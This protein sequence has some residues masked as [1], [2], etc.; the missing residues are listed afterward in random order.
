[1]LA[2]IR[3]G[4]CLTSCPTYVLSMHESEGPR[5]RVGMARALAEGHLQV[6][7]DLV[8]HELNCLVC[9]ACSAVC[10]AGVHM[11]PLQVRLRSAIEPDMRRPWRERLLRGLV[12]GWLFMD[13]ARFRLVARLLWVY[14]RSGARWLARRLGLLRVLGLGSSEQLLP[15]VPTR[16][17]V[18]SDDVYPASPG[19]GREVAFF[20]GCVMSTALA[21]IDRATIRVVQRAGHTVRNPRGQGCC[22]ALHA[23]SGD[24]R[25]ALELAR[26]NIAVFEATDGPIVVNSAGCGA[27]LKDYA[28]HFREDSGWAQRAQSFSARV[29][30]LSEVLAPE[31]LPMRKPIAARV[32]YQD[33]CHLLHAQRISRQ[34]RDLLRRITGLELTEIAE[35]G[36]CCGSAGVYNLTNPVQSRQLQQR[37][38]DNAL[39]ADPHIIVTAN[40]GCLLQ[41]RAGLSER[42]SRVNVVH[43]AEL[44]DTATAPPSDASSPA[45]PTGG[46]RR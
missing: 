2:C 5:G 10:P 13:M 39:A 20:A 14:Q 23:H 30:D 4:L 17:L 1:M 16:F 28:H 45:E 29:K 12:F 36:L 40:P 33:A 21:D 37:K 32:V 24:L 41:L 43:L 9:D 18:P 19:A 11:D 46:S 42:H 34:P 3:C 22:G 35:A 6:T 27:M 26:A 15:D 8:E 38:L 25:R 31:S 7:P 44:L